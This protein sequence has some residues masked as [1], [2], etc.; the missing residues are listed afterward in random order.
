MARRDAEAQRNKE[1]KE[2][3][4][5]RGTEPQK[6]FNCAEDAKGKPFRPN[7]DLGTS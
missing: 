6:H 4:A 3:N 1:K 5:H 2:G 7:V